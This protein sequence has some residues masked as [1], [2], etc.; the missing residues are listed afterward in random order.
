[1]G[2]VL[3]IAA[4][5]SAAETLRRLQAVEPYAIEKGATAAQMAAGC[6]LFDV[7]AESGPVGAV[8]VAVLE[9]AGE[10]AFYIAAAAADTA[11][12]GVAALMEWAKGEAD[13]I[14][15]DYIECSTKR[16]GLVRLLTRAGCTAQRTP[17]GWH[18][19]KRA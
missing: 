8:A 16:R 14:G 15:A 6:A 19:Y 5:A 17:W 2:V 10:R 1:M 18:V 3:T 7:V 4:P 13:R 9:E 11:A 12:G